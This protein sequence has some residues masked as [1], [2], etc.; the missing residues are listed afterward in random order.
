MEMKDDF[1]KLNEIVE[2]ASMRPELS[3]VRTSFD[4]AISHRINRQ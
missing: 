2:K 3:M 4:I 1:L